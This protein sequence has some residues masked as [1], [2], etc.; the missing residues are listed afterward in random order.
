MNLVAGT[1]AARAASRAQAQALIEVV[2]W[3]ALADR[4]RSERLLALLGERIIAAADGRA[5]AE[6]VEATAAALDAGRAQHAALELITIQLTD[7]FRGAGI[8]SLP[9]KGPTLGGAIYGETGRRPSGDIDLLV[10]SEDL[11][12]AVAVAERL[13]YRDWYEF[14]VRGELPRLHVTLTREGL[15]PLELHWRVHWYESRFSRDLLVRST[16]GGQVGRRAIPSDE[17]TS[18]LLFYERDGFLGLRLACDLAAWWDR[19]GSELEAGAMHEMIGGYP[20]LARALLAAAIVAERVVALPSRELLHGEHALERRVRLAIAL[21]NPDS[22]GSVKQRT[23]DTWLVDWLLTPRGGRRECIR[24][25]L[26]APSDSPRG[27]Y[28]VLASLNR[29]ARLLRRYAISVARAAGDQ[30]RRRRYSVT[31]RP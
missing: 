7:S 15:P 3:T 17:L 26:R 9:L 31:S 28:D 24:R 10:R 23:A 12:G 21:A 2:D 19:L 5:P 8:Q 11:P 27:H 30:A 18:L 4:L 29:G 20:E 22:H 13:G 6:F 16:E 1:A 14:A 25:Q